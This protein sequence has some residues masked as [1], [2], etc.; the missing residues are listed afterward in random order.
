MRLGSVEIV[1]YR[2]VK[3]ALTLRI[4]PAVTVIL[5]ANDH[6]KTNVLDAVAHLNPDQVFAQDDLNWDMVDNGDRYPKVTY[7][8]DLSPYDMRTLAQRWDAMAGKAD[9]AEKERIDAIL[10]GGPASLKVIREGLSGEHTYGSFDSEGFDEIVT[11]F[12]RGRLPR[13]EIIRPFATLNDTVDGWGIRE[14]DN[15]FMQGVF[16]ASGLDPFESEWIFAQN[17]RTSR[18]LTDA[19]EVLNENLRGIWAQGRNAS[20]NFRLEHRGGDQIHLLVEDPSVESMYVQA[21]RRSSGFTNFFATSLLLYARRKKHPAASY[22]FLFDEPGIYLHP[23]G[24]RDYIHV[25]ET[26][27]LTSQV[28]YATHSPFMSN[29]NFPGRHR[30]VEKDGNGTR[31]SDASSAEWGSASEQPFAESV[32][33]TE[34]DV[35]PTY[36]LAMLQWLIAANEIAF[37]I[38]GLSIRPVTNAADATIL[39]QELGGDGTSLGIVVGGLGYGDKLIE[40][41]VEAIEDGKVAGKTLNVSTSAEDH[42]PLI[43]TLFVEAVARHWHKLGIANGALEGIAVSELIEA[44]SADFTAT[45]QNAEITH[46]VAK[47]A[48]E[49]GGKLYPNV[50]PEEPS[51]IGI[52][53]EYVKLLMATDPADVDSANLYR[54]AKDLADWIGTALKLP[55]RHAEHRV[56]EDPP[57]G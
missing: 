23:T 28:M 13:V 11:E 50:L 2:S 46:G 9:A 43:G 19:S 6:G 20:L 10:D 39:A 15:E 35:A 44:V 55:P 48:D 1:G 38:N 52:A 3:E 49:I 45:F 34:G 53:S 42:V 54:R 24:Q 36:I 56:V 17:N 57:N 25:L 5:G 30:V 4:D 29:R 31:R 12:L 33:L 8:F 14:P 47:W 40:P 51:K 18:R 37:D 21:S 7:T 27:S 32:L 41:L 26:A 16:Y 22:I